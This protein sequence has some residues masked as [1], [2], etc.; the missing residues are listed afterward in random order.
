MNAT[1][2]NNT[3]EKRFWS[4]VNK[5]TECWNWTGYFVGNR[6]GRI[7][8]NGKVHRAHRMSWI[9]HNGE[10]P[11]GM[12]VLHKC[13]NPSCVNPDHL[14]IGT[15]ADNMAD[16]DAKGR[17]AN[18]KGANNGNSKLTEAKVR[19]IRMWSELGYLQKRIATAYGVSKVN[20]SAIKH[21]RSWKH[22]ITHEFT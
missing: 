17:R 7:K 14:F 9:I 8:L 2:L 13:D 11:T 5:E 12:C 10:I 20:V 21:R 6:Y 18:F 22:V 4:R 15:R 16:M 19:E 3:T 1:A